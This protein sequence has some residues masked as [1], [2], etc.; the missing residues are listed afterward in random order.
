[1]KT[2][3]VNIPS[4]INDGLEILVRM[5][6]FANRSEAIRVGLR[7]FLKAELPMQD[8]ALVCDETK[9]AIELKKEEPPEEPNPIPQIVDA[10]K[11][12]VENK[13][14]TLPRRFW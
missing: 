11:N 6:K 7:E 12:A 9:P 13:E 14:D 4:V 2:I 1:M 5:G 10:V 8:L 3:S